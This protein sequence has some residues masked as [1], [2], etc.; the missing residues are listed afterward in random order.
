MQDLLKV[1]EQIRQRIN[2][3]RDRLTR[4]E[5]L[6]RYSLIDPLLRAL[7]WDT[8]DPD[9]VEPEFSTQQGR[10]DYALQHNK[11][12]FILIEAKPLESNLSQARDSGF[13]YCWQNKVP[14]YVI[15]DGNIWEL[16]DLR[17][18][19]GRQIFRVCL[20]EDSLGDVARKLLAIWRPAMPLVQLGPP[21]TS[22]LSQSHSRIYVLSH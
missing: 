12:P 4:N 6:T 10:P 13:K 1:I 8:E 2:T 17:E 16:H 3:F 20:A 11:Q 14:F 9:Q 18:M 22:P 19:G 15:T 7:G 5:M 21:V